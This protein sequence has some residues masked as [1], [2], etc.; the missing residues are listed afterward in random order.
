MTCVYWGGCRRALPRPVTP[1]PSPGPR[2]AGSQHPARSPRTTY[3]LERSVEIVYL[4]LAH[5]ERLAYASCVSHVG[6]LVTGL[7]H[8]QRKNCVSYLSHGH[9]EDK[10]GQGGSTTTLIGHA[11]A[12]PNGDWSQLA[13]DMTKYGNGCFVIGAKS[14]PQTSL[15]GNQE[16]L[17][18]E[19][20]RALGSRHAGIRRAPALF[21]ICVLILPI[22]SDSKK[23]TLAKS[24]WLNWGVLTS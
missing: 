10:E 22:H 1:C 7:C 2:P 15:C 18:G 5:H 9:V 3:R 23:S 14:R 12:P 19:S 24:L 16:A 20:S 8:S 11:P 4:L 13:T 6:R 21:R 17:W